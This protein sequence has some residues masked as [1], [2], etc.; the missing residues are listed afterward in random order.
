MGKKEKKFLVK[1]L[2]CRDKIIQEIYMRRSNTELIGRRT[3]IYIR[4][5]KMIV[6]LRKIYSLTSKSIVAAVRF[7][8]RCTY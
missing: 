7:E 2:F 6:W 5:F 4:G 3:V 8:I 1:E